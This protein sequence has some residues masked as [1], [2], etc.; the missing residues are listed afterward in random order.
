MDEEFL[1]FIDETG[2]H[3][4]Q[5]IDMEYPIFGLGALFCKYDHYVRHIN[6]IFDDLKYKYFNK[7]H[8]LLHSTDIRRRRKDFN[9]LLHPETRENFFN[10]LNTAIQEAP[11]FFVT[12]FVDKLKHSEQYVDPDNPYDLTLS[13]IMERSFF[14]IKKR[15]PN[16]KCRFIAESRDHA[17][18]SKLLKTF[19]YLKTVGTSFVSAAELEFIS[20][21]DFVKK[22]ENETGHQIV[23]LCLYPLARTYL[24]GECHPSVPIFYDKIYKSPSGSPSGY[25]LKTFPSG[26]SRTLIEEIESKCR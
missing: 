22:E 3:S 24:K 23:D 26:I 15:Y 16:A 2:D 21:L 9:I 10:D 20:S 14:L 19:E 11:F 1:V 5:H 6:P 13:F 18:N 25:G 12:S 7:R 8:V 17:E 4:L